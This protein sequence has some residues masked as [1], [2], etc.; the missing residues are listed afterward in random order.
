MS[1]I[2]INGVTHTV[3]DLLENDDL[4][5]ALIK[6][7]YDQFTYL[8]E[9]A[10][11][12]GNITE[13]SERVLGALFDTKCL[14]DVRNDHDTYYYTI[15]ILPLML[16]DSSNILF[17]SKTYLDNLFF[18]EAHKI[19]PKCRDALVDFPLYLFMYDLYTSKN[20]F[21]RA[22]KQLVV[23]INVLRSQV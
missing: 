4:K 2:I 12:K 15:R 20:I 14:Y 10:F 16:K 17:F 3:D 11:K 5:I 18:N 19:N 7:N 21:Y 6:K 13:F 8:I 9:D 22:L 1:K 23:S